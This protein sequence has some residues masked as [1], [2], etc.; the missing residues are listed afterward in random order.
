[1]ASDA[2]DVLTLSAHEVHLRSGAT[3]SATDPP[4]IC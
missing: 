3:R 1:M 2:Y 4:S